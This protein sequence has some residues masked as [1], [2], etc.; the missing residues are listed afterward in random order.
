MN[1]KNRQLKYLLLLNLGML[2]ISTSGALG[3][4][5]Q[6]PPP[7]TIWWRAFFAIFFLGAFLLI[8]K[9]PFAI[10]FKKKGGILLISGI[11]MAA[12]WITYFYALQWSNVTIAML[13]LFTYPVMT[14]LLEPLFLKTPFQSRHIF[15]GGL[16]LAGVYFLAPE[17]N[18]ENAMTQG[19]LIGLLSAFVYSLRNILLKTQINVLNGSVLMFYQMV[20]TVMLTAPTLFIYQDAPV[21]DYWPY[22]LMLGLI[23]TSIGHT[24]FLNSFKH[25]SVSSASLL[26]GMQP[27]YGIVLAA[28]F[29]H[30]FPSWWNVIGGVLII[31]AVLLESRLSGK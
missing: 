27:I 18:P 1:L 13:S 19:L 3:R 20:V 22:L 4:Y 8:K 14:A 2:C 30:E 10:N 31:A 9:Y 28:I 25:F 11:L 7:L 29:L 12:H 16:V 26:G 24:L 23:T 17:L 5:I 6:L 21:S 15:L